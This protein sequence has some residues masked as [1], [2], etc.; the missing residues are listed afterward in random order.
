[1][2]VLFV[3]GVF[4][5]AVQSYG[6]PI[7]FRARGEGVR[8]F[9]DEVNRKDDNNAL[10]GHPEDFELHLLAMFDEAKGTFASVEVECLVRGKDASHDAP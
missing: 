1:M 9:T 5:S 8:S 10:Y 2:S 3:C 7:F 6:R 4:D